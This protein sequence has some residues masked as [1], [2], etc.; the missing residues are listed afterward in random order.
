MEFLIDIVMSGWSIV[1][2]EGLQIMTSKIFDV[3]FS[4]DPFRLANIADF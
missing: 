3:S 2:Y 1:Y 4:Q